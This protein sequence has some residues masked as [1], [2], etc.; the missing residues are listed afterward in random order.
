[1]PLLVSSISDS[2]DDFCTSLGFG[3]PV[4]EAMACGCPVITS[5]ISSM[6]ELGSDAAYYIDPYDNNSITEG[7]IKLIKNSDLRN[8]LIK[9]GNY[10]AKLFTRENT[11]K[12]YINIFKILVR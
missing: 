6:P 10:R 8:K 2:L 1:M 3:L 9:K 12:K 7:I 11:N 5:N 4:I